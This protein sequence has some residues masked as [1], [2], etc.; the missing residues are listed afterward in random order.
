MSQ[1]YAGLVQSSDSQLL[2]MLQVHIF[3]CIIYYFYAKARAVQA[4]ATHIRAPPTQSYPDP[5]PHNHTERKVKRKRKPT[6][7]TI[8]S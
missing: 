4:C 7:P 2:Y 5:H 8:L 1:V 6:K 3:S